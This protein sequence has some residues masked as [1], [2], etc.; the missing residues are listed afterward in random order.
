MLRDHLFHQKI[1]EMLALVCETF[2]E[3]KLA[4][5]HD[6]RTQYIKKIAWVAPLRVRSQPI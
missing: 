2:H 5:A 4:T 1:K 6:I 3:Q